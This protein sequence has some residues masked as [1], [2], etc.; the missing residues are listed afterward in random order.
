MPLPKYA[1][2]AETL[3]LRIDR[4]QYR[5]GALMPTEAELTREFAASRATVVRALRQL[6]RQGWLRGIQ[7]KG[8]VIL[9]RPADPLCAL[10]ARVQV[11]L[12]SDRHA[13]LLGVYRQPATPKVGRALRRPAGSLVIARRYLLSLPSTP[14]IGLS[15]V[16]VPEPLMPAALT[17]NG[18]LLAYLEQRNGLRATKI[19]ERLTARLATRSE[20]EALEQPTLRT[21]S[22]TELTVLDGHHV[23]FL[24]VEA[25]LARDAVQLITTYDV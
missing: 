24:T 6:S 13:A 16:Y 4:R 20:I 2:I 12:Q 17:P 14:P 1:E 25:V 8:R 23:P 10:P 7:G 3:Q 11:L 22:V 15:T 21:V 5:V 9:G 18:T 19:V